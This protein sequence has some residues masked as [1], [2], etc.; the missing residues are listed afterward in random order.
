M[1]LIKVVIPK[2]VTAADANE[3]RVVR[4]SS[5]R[6]AVEPNVSRFGEHQKE[7]LERLEKERKV[8]AT[9]EEALKYAKGTGKSFSVLDEAAEGAA[10]DA[11]KT[12]WN[13]EYTKLVETIK[14]LIKKAEADGQ[15]STAKA[16]MD[17][18]KVLRGY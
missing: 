3:I 8:F 18:L 11:A 17:C 5:G 12:D 6:Y 13:W 14:K 2:K 15:E 9:K 7:N 1:S 4:I 10:Q 16:F